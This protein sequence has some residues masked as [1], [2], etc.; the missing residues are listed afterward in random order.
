MNTTTND[1]PQPDSATRPDCARASGSAPPFPRRHPS[2]PQTVEEC[3]EAIAYWSFI[4]RH[5]GLC[6][7]ESDLSSTI[8]ALLDLRLQ[9]EKPNTEVSNPGH[10]NTL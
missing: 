4:Q 1:N 2:A 10:Q 7:Q 5:T 6:V 9:I 3:D 8:D